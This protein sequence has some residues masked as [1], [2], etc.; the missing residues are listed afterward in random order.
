MPLRCSLYTA[1]LI[2]TEAAAERFLIVARTRGLGEFTLEAAD[3]GT[4]F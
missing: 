3:M 2:S 1:S 4:A